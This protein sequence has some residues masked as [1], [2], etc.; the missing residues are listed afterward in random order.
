MPKRSSLAES[1][2]HFHHPLGQLRHSSFG[3]YWRQVSHLQLQ[4]RR[5]FQSPSGRQCPWAS[6]VDTVRLW[7]RR[8][9][10]DV[11]RCML[12]RMSMLDT[13][14][15]QKC[16]DAEKAVLSAGIRRQAA[17]CALR[18]MRRPRMKRFH[19]LHPHVH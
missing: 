10:Q 12:V 4:L 18:R 19:P 17:R 3:K 13:H 7:V 14:R 2:A 5:R 15:V 9:L 6:D 16:R 1:F 11:C 8:G